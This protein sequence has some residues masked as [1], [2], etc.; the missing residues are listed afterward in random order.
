[1]DRWPLILDSLTYKWWNEIQSTAMYLQLEQWNLHHFSLSKITKFTHL[2]PLLPRPVKSLYLL[3]NVHYFLV[4]RISLL[5]AVPQT[6]V[7]YVSRFCSSFSGQLTY[8]FTRTLQEIRS[9]VHVQ[10]RFICPSVQLNGVEVSSRSRFRTEDNISVL[11]YWV[12]SC[13]GARLQK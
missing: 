4:E 13:C 8:K 1:M 5:T 10:C 7:L 3:G 9:F 2:K 12:L 6:P 11:L